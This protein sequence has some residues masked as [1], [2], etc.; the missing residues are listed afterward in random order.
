M[1]TFQT[2]NDF[3][4][5]PFGEKE[6]KSKD[7]ERKFSELDSNRKIKVVGLTQVEDD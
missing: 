5:K 4:D 1:E 2:I 7:F 6:E 3:L